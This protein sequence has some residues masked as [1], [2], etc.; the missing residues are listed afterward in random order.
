VYGYNAAGEPVAELT[1]D[2][3]DIGWT[4]H[5]ADKKAAWYQFQL[6]LDILRSGCRARQYAPQRQGARRGA[7]PTGHR[8]G[9]AL[10]SRPARGPAR[11]PVRHGL[12]PRE[13]R[14][15]G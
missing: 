7:W 15:S 5:V 3:A 11:V 1:A 2:N 10:D 4:V 13:A 12:L 6:A 8:P 14:S 9:S